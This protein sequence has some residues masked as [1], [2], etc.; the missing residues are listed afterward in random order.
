MPAKHKKSLL[1]CFDAGV[2]LALLD[3]GC[4]CL[5]SGRKSKILAGQA[6]LIALNEGTSEDLS[7]RWAKKSK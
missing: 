4:C 1:N 2:H 6:E 5:T 7:V 3:K